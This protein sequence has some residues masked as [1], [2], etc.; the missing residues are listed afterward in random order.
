[1]VPEREEEEKLLINIEEEGDDLFDLKLSEENKFNGKSE[2][3]NYS[4][5]VDNKFS[6]K[7]QSK[8]FDN[9]NSIIMLPKN[10]DNKIESKNILIQ[11]LEVPSNQNVIII[12][13]V[14]H[15]KRENDKVE[16][17]ESKKK[18]ELGFNV[19]EENSQMLN[20]FSQR[21]SQS[22]KTLNVDKNEENDFNLRFSLSTKKPMRKD[23][24]EG[25]RNIIEV[26]IIMFNLCK[27]H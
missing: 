26:K 12:S 6:N 25:E 19:I 22:N 15:D 24:E 23:D 2:N 27:N 9:T 11:K 14:N 16:N 20:K 5:D 4:V 13:G 1:M 10:S 3:L 7:V 18:I 8:Q 17:V 21:F